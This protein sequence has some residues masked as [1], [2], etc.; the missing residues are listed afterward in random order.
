MSQKQLIIIDDFSPNAKEIRELALSKEYSTVHFAGNDYPGI[1]QE[2][3]VEEQLRKHLCPMMAAAIGWEAIIPRLSLFRCATSKH[4]PDIHIH[5]D[6]AIGTDGFGKGAE[7]IWA[8]VFHLSKPEACEGGTAF[9]THKKY[10]WDF[11]PCK[12]EI[13]QQGYVKDQ[14]FCD[15]LN[16]DGHFEDRWTMNSLAGMKFN[17]M[18]LYPG[19]LFHSRYP[20]HARGDRQ[21]DGRLIWVCF[22]DKA[23]VESKIDVHNPLLVPV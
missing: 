4:R 5:A 8:A 11:L 19:N 18:V 6:N 15:E 17:R 12:E 2:V 1:S 23:T 14:T 7:S 9:W 22:F 10:G 3:Q 20:V 13:E 21:E 16:A